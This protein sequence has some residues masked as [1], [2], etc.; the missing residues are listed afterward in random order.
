MRS[1]RRLLIRTFS[2][3]TSATGGNGQVQQKVPMQARR[4]GFAQQLSGFAEFKAAS[5]HISKGQLSLALPL[6]RRVYEVVS[7]ALG[8]SSDL[9]ANVALRVAIL[10]RSLGEYERAEACLMMG[11]LEGERL[12]DA[13]HFAAANRLLSGSPAAAKDAALEALAKSEELHDSSSPLHASEAAGADEEQELPVAIS[14]SLA[15][16]CHLY[17]GKHEEALSHLQKAARW[18]NTVEGRVRGLVNLG[19]FYWLV[20][21]AREGGSADEGGDHIGSDLG[22]RQD[23]RLLRIS[24][25][26]GTRV[27][28]SDASTAASAEELEGVSEAMG[29][30]EEA[31]GEVV[32]QQTKIKKPVVASTT[33]GGKEAEEAVAVSPSKWALSPSMIPLLVDTSF[34]SAYTTLL[35]NISCGLALQGKEEDAYVSISQ[36]LQTLDQRSRTAATSDTLPLK[37]TILTTLLSRTLCT[38]AF[39]QMDAGKAVTSEGLF[40]AACDLSPS[41]LQDTNARL[42]HAAALG[43]YGL[44]LK[45]WEKREKESEGLRTRSADVVKGIRRVGRGEIFSSFLLLPPGADER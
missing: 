3:S 6:M 36:A 33:N 41:E 9:T 24:Q 45:S 40:R 27:G 4:L 28:K 31:L 11:S 14:H 39:H 16:I 5:A 38:L 19:A 13:L 8:P 44:L 1:P 21:G 18:S 25:G 15:G 10:H 37:P 34:V 2:C 17:L 42:E 20:G 22:H 12:I 23:W 32:E 43:G 26:K 30:W 35:N 29:C 7:N